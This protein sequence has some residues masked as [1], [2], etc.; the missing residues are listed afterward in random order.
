VILAFLGDVMAAMTLHATFGAGR[1]A[2][3]AMRWLAARDLAL[4][5]AIGASAA[6][7]VL[8]FI[9]YASTLDWRQHKRP[10]LRLSLLATGVGMVAVVLILGVLDIPLEQPVVLAAALGL[11]LIPLL[12]IWPLE[13]ALGKSLASLAAL[14]AASRT[15]RAAFLARQALRFSPKNS[16]ARRSL[17]L[18]LYYSRRHSE[19]YPHLI[20][21][22]SQGERTP[23][24]LQAL[25]ATTEAMGDLTTALNHLEELALMLPL[26]DQVLADRVRLNRELNR[27]ADART[28]IEEVEPARRAAWRDVRIELLV[29]LA[30]VDAIVDEARQ[31]EAEQGPPF[32]RA[33]NLFQQAHAFAPDNTSH[34]R[35]LIRLAHLAGDSDELRARLEE[36]IP[37]H[38]GDASLLRQLRNETMAQ[39]DAARAAELLNQIG[40]L[41]AAAETECLELAQIHADR[42]D[43]DGMM[44]WLQMHD[45]APARTG[46]GAAMIVRTLF[47][48]GRHDEALHAAQQ[49]RNGGWLFGTHADEVAI[50][51]SRIHA[52]ALSSAVSALGQEALAHPDD[53]D[54]QFQ[55]LERLCQSGA[56]DK[57]TLYAEQMLQRHGDPFRERL[58][59]QLPHWASLAPQGRS[60]RL[61][62]Y[63]GDLRLR[64]GDVDGAFVCY[65]EASGL[66]M[67][68]DASLMEMTKRVLNTDPNH[69]PAHRTAAALLLRAGDPRGSLRHID[70]LGD[71]GHDSPDGDDLQLIEFQAATQTGA[72]QRAIHAG[73]AILATQHYQQRI[74]LH[75][76]LADLLMTQGRFD[77][78][79]QLLDQL[80]QRFPED[81][82][83]RARMRLAYE[84]RKNARIERLRAE[85]S[86]HPRSPELLEEL[87]DLLLADGKLEEAVVEFQK[88][89]HIGPEYRRARAKLAF[90]LARKGL[91]AESDEAYAETE[92]QPSL[93]PEELAYLKD[94]FYDGAL[95]MEK[96][97]ESDRAL[98]LYK[99]I[100]RVDMGFKDVLARIERL[101]RSQ[102]RRT[103]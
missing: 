47:E 98:G 91:H 74:D 93:P 92:L 66:S 97:R 36:A 10:A 7:V 53:F 77:D 67:N 9:G 17:G 50:V 8:T 16:T 54:L 29:E 88:A 75:L 42:G 20:H 1:L 59:E 102:K 31:H 33:R 62:E 11:I 87:G 28:L 71:L 56:T 63:S 100:S 57:V 55:Y 18:G 49:A 99:R 79:C 34:L 46:R 65:T 51:E 96:D 12:G 25:A 45:G 103:I 85:L 68:P 70:R 81:M 21:A 5:A 73:Q 101:T 52:M 40:A 72:A 83:V 19:A 76:Q 86:A 39:G 82:S 44:T 32:R 23:P 37:L 2:E 38:P 30:D 6:A 22:Y 78:A 95:L 24:L 26:D 48:S 14:A 60:M 84:R 58:Q 13:M 69:I 80:H 3:D 35:E 41:S 61:I 4:P 43:I 64:C 94:L 27:P 90:C 89:A 15:P